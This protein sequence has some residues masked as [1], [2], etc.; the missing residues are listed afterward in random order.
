MN[1]P[2][3]NSDI[4]Y[5]LLT[6]LSH[7][8]TKQNFILKH[9]PYTLAD[10]P[11]YSQLPSITILQKIKYEFDPFFLRKFHLES[12]TP[13]STVTKGDANGILRKFRR[14]KIPTPDIENK[15]SFPP[16]IM[17][18]ILIVKNEDLLEDL[19]DILPG[20]RVYLAIDRET[21]DSSE[22]WMEFD[23]RLKLVMNVGT[24]DLVKYAKE[25]F[26]RKV[27]IGE[28]DVYVENVL[29]VGEKTDDA[30]TEDL[31]ISFYQLNKIL[32]M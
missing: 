10:T 13:F 6:A 19:A 31:F 8:T 29:M 23:K 11:T 4:N 17:P 27:K 9:L 21:H 12:Y 18:E 3:D 30:A 32:K 22:R 1:L 15:S 5:H 26:K 2:N 20:K 16:F 25:K 14:A 28:L 24:E 7:A